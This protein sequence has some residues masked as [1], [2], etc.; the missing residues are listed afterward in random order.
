MAPML[1]VSVHW[2]RKDRC[3]NRVIPFIKMGP[4]LIRYIPARVFETLNKNY[5]EG[6]PSH[7]K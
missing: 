4:H 7:S 3:G 2:L 1:A 5:T 6:G